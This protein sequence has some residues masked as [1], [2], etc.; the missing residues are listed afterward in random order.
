MPGGRMST[1]GAATAQT[2][3]NHRRQPDQAA[4]SLS[5][6]GTT[7]EAREQGPEGR[8]IGRPAEMKG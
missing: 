3:Q 1:P 8:V 2:R 7:A 5:V 4:G 6:T